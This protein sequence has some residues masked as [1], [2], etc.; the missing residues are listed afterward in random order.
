MTLATPHAP[1][2]R[3]RSSA[4]Q[5]TQ[6][7]YSVYGAAVRSEVRLPLATIPRPLGVADGILVRRMSG[8]AVAEPGGIVVAT[9]TC[10]VHGEVLRVHRGADGT[11]IRLQGIGAFHISPES[12]E[13]R[14]YAEDGADERALAHA[15]LQPVLLHLQQVRGHL[16]L[17]ASAVVTDRGA[18]AFLGPSGQGKST[19]TAAFLRRGAAMLTDDALVLKEHGNVHLGVPGPSFMKVWH[20][21]ATHTLEMTEHLPD[22]MAHLDKKLLTLDGRFKQAAGPEPLRA[23]YVLVRYDPIAAGSSDITLRRLSARDALA[24]MLANTSNR[25]YLLPRE[26]GALLPQYTHLAARTPVNVLAYPS[27]F[28]RQSAVYGRILEDL[29]G[30]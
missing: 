4:P 10:D 5:R 9:R 21:T 18:I 2:R 17:H 16:S 26:E 12:Q 11:W 24:V 25:D 28:E 8:G 1:A 29:E 14:V 23:L 13:V 7:W 20:E 15:L 19:M 6:H 3:A 22:L 27:G 30:Q